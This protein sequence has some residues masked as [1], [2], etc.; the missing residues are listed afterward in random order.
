MQS[1]QTYTQTTAN[2]ATHTRLLYQEPQDENQHT[3]SMIVVSICHP[4]Y[5]GNY[6]DARCKQIDGKSVYDIVNHYY[7]TD[8]KGNMKKYKMRDLLYDIKTSRIL[9]ETK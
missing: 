2:G 8:S 6:I 4:P 5:G 9:I 7:Y 3:T 1:F